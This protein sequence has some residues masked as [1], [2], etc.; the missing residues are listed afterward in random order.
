MPTNLIILIIL[1]CVAAAAIVGTLIFAWA[2]DRRLERERTAT[3][4]S[5][6]DAGERSG[7]DPGDGPGEGSG[8]HPR[9][10]ET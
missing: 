2:V 5:P 3:A 10:R 1:L 8:G 7:R 4:S 6:P 9:G